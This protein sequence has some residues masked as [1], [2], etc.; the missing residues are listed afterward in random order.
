MDTIH[1]FLRARHEVASAALCAVVAVTAVP[2]AADTLTD[3]PVGH[4]GAKC[5]D[6]ANDLVARNAR[7]LLAEQTMLGDLVATAR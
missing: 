3:L 4:A 5:H 7:E 6:L 2:A 1:V